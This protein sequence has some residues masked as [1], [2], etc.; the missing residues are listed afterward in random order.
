MPDNVNTKAIMTSALSFDIE[1]GWSLFSRDWLLQQIETTDTVVKDTKV[2]LNILEQHNVH[3]TFFVLGNV[4]EKF[5][6][7]VRQIADMGHEIGTHGFSHKQLFKLDPEQF[8]LEVSRAKKLLEDITGTKVLGH[9]APAFSVMPKT[10]WSFEILAQEGFKY[11]SSVVPCTN[12]RY[13]WAGFSKD[14]CKIKLPNGLSI[15]EFPMSTINIPVLGKGFVVGGGYLRHFPYAVTKWAIRY[16]QKQRP[17]VIYMHPY[18][19]GIEKV[20]FSVDHLPEK[21]RTKTLR[22]LKIA[23]RNTDTVYGKL[24]RLLRDFQFTTISRIIEDVCV[25]SFELYKI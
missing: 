19:M 11:D 1:D 18:E 16:I 9:R 12:S 20:P 14:I 6:Q 23:T 24:N 25:E 4:A 2:I 5:P 17:V 15:I 3:A 21:D 22:Y 10:K 8:R 7:L 13:G